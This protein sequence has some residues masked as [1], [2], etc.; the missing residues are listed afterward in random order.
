L[1]VFSLKKSEGKDSA[2]WAVSGFPLLASRSTP[3]APRSLKQR[4]NEGRG[5]GAAEDDEDADQQENN[6]DRGDEVGLVRQDE[7]EQFGDE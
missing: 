2:Q 7:V 6:D 1:A 5:F 3:P 4:V